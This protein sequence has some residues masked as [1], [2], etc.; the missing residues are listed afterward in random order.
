MRVRKDEDLD[1]MENEHRIEIEKLLI[2]ISRL[3]E[4]IYD[5]ERAKK[6]EQQRVKEETEHMYLLQ[7]SNLKKSHAAQVEI[8]EA[9]VRK[10]RDSLSEKTDHLEEMCKSAEKERKMFEKQIE[11]LR[12]EL[13]EVLDKKNDE[14]DAMREED[15]EKLKTLQKQ[16]EEEIE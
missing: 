2:E 9:T 3:H 14:L 5:L 10:T 16:M 7:I 11:S 12:A 15:G 13:K 4:F 1:R 6:S 8:L